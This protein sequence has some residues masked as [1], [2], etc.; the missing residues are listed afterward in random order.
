LNV[1]SIAVQ[2]PISR[3]TS[4]SSKPTNYTDAAATIGVWTTASRQATTVLGS[5][6]V[7]PW[8]QVSRL[9][10]P[11]VNEVLIPMGRKDYWNTQSPSGDSQFASHYAHP[12]L[13]GLL[14]VLYPK[15][16]P[17]LKKLTAARA[18]LEAILLTGMPDGIIPGFQNYTGSTQADLLRLNVAVKPAAKPSILGILGGDLAGFPNG[19][20]PYDDIVSIELRAVAGATYPLVDKSYKADAAAAALF[21]IVDPAKTTP[22]SLSAIGVNFLGWFPYLMPGWSGFTNPAKTDKPALAGAE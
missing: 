13:A 17:N 21:D 20:R 12:E 14:S 18:D 5:K 7:G 15:A 22:E 6:S 9:G 19:R 1:H 8:T 4:N 16:F 3:L 2:V 11:L 10:N